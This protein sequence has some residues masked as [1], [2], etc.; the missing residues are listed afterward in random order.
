MTIILAMLK[1]NG[2]EIKDNRKL[3]M[4]MTI[5]SQPNFKF[6]SVVRRNDRFSISAT[7]SIL[8]IEQSKRYIKELMKVNY[9]LKTI[10]DA[11][12]DGL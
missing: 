1:Q 4:G 9:L 12:D 10:N 5:I 2:L 8:T 6:I 7:G 11:L 3:G